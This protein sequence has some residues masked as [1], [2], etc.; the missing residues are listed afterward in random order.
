MPEATL[1]AF[2]DH[3]ELA[4]VIS[5]EQSDVETVMQ[6]FREAGIDVD[7]LGVELQTEGAKSLVKYWDELMDVITSK[8]TELARVGSTASR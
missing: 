2:G 4:D 5:P 3:G 7:A 8:S 6:Q 1:K